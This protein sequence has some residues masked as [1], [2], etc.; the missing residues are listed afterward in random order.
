MTRSP[1]H[2]WGQEHGHTGDTVWPSPPELNVGTL[3]APSTC[4]HAQRTR[5]RPVFPRGRS[6]DT[7]PTA[8]RT[9]P[10][11][12]G[13]HRAAVTWSPP[14]PCRQVTVT[15]VPPRNPDA[16]DPFCAGAR[17]PRCHARALRVSGE[18]VWR[19]GGRGDC[20][21]RRRWETRG[22]SPPGGQGPT[23]K[24]WPVCVCSPC[25]SAKCTG[26]ARFC[27]RTL[28][29]AVFPCTLPACSPEVWGGPSARAR[30]PSPTLGRQLG[31]QGAPARPA[32]PGSSQS[33]GGCCPDRWRQD[34]GA[35]V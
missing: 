13:E 8:Q 35:L 1:T 2:G 9:V 34:R 4:T 15:G 12:L 22:Q 30:R 10:C 21:T 18:Q 23:R 24:A 6:K 29:H 11:R 5:H 20:R 16:G 25:K 17:Q 14:L 27:T 32:C 28:R 33:P 26:S 19:G 7:S 3:H 31:G